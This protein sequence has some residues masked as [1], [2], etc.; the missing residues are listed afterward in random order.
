LHVCPENETAI[1]LYEKI[2]FNLK[3]LTKSINPKRNNMLLMQIDLSAS[4]LTEKVNDGQ[5]V[6]SRILHAEPGARK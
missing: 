2:G 3:R 6:E 5:Q 4:A 1:R